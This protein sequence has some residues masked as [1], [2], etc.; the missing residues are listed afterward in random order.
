MTMAIGHY[1]VILFS[2]T[3]VS[4]LSGTMKVGTMSLLTTCLAVICVGCCCCCIGN[5]T[6]FSFAARS[7]RMLPFTK[8]NFSLTHVN[9]TEIQQI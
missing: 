9:I 7:H 5:S 8:D 4:G 1:L 6:V 2:G 3:L